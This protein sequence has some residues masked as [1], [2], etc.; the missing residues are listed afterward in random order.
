MSFFLN[1]NLKV[2][3]AVYGC[4]IYGYVSTFPQNYTQSVCIGQVCAGMFAAICEIITLAFINDPNETG[5]MY[6]LI[7][8]AFMLLNL[9]SY[10]FMTKMKFASYYRKNDS[11][12]NINST[13]NDESTPL[14]NNT[15]EA[16]Q[17]SDLKVIKLTF[18][19]VR[20]FV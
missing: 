1:F 6:F 5:L 19:Q 20:E 13:E 17:N 10:F 18:K 15:P 4:S 14:V 16:K 12:I 8:S 3:A 11:I 7:A 9:I 2:F